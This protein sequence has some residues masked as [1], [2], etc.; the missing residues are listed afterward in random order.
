MREAHHLRD[1]GPTH[2]LNGDRACKHARFGDI[3]CEPATF[4]SSVVISKLRQLSVRSK[5]I[6]K[7]YY[8][9]I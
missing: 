1:L 6:N 7:L 5:I 9:V 8:V 3:F 4:N 2:G